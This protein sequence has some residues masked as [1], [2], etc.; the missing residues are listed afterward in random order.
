VVCGLKF[1]VISVYG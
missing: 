1:S